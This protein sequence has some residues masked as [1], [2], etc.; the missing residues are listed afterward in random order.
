[1]AKKIYSFYFLHLPKHLSDQSRAEALANITHE[2]WELVTCYPSTYQIPSTRLDAVSLF[3]TMEE[4]VFV[5]RSW[6]KVKR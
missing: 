5:F 4:T 1:M 6:R 3:E 2:G